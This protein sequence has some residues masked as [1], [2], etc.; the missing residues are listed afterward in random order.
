V[1]RVATDARHFNFEDFGAEIR[2]ELPAV[3]TRDAVRQFKNSQMAQRGHTSDL[4]AG[5]VKHYLSSRG[6]LPG[7]VPGHIRLIATPDKNEHPTA[8]RPRLSC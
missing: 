6:A 3:F 5:A 2:K 4:V 1:A 8:S 7:G